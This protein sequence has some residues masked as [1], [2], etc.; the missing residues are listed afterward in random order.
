MLVIDS[1]TSEHSGDYTCV[2]SNAA[3]SVNTTVRLAV[4][5]KE[6]QIYQIVLNYAPYISSLYV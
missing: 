1:T 4:N 5:G 3:S 6:A 2:A